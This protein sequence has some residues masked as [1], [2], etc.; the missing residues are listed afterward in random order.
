MSRG[1]AVAYM[2][3]TRTLLMGGRKYQ[4]KAWQRISQSIFMLEVML[5][6]KSWL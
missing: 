1:A 4:V 6:A 5:T 2:Y 3:S